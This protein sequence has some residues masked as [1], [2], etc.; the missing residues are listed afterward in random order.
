MSAIIVFFYLIIFVAIFVKIFKF[1]KSFNGSNSMID[2]I[3][4]MIKNRFNSVI[5]DQVCR[6]NNNTDVDLDSFMKSN[7][8]PIKEVK[9]K[10]GKI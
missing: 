7:I 8:N 10:R 2:N 5:N 3:N 6:D 4:S 9:G 1:L